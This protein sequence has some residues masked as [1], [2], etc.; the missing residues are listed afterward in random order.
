MWTWVLLALA[1]A[2]I[3]VLLIRRAIARDRLRARRVR[4]AHELHE[5]IRQRGKDTVLRLRGREQF[6]QLA[7][8]DKRAVVYLTHF[9]WAIL[10]TL[11]PIPG[12]YY[13]GSTW[14]RIGSLLY[15]YGRLRSLP[16]QVVRSETVCLLQQ[17][18][19]LSLGAHMAEVMRPIEHS[20]PLRQQVVA[21]MEHVL[22]PIVGTILF[23]A[24]LLSFHYITGIPLD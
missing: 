24:A 16:P 19:N 2:I 22:L 1:A 18:T 6:G 12:R 23:M 10:Y 14:R 21:V 8:K 9:L 3:V 20:R 13:A 17:I 15:C 4:E 11:V 5:Q 7:G